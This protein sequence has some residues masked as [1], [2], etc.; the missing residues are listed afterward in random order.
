MMYNIFIDGK[1]GTTGLQ[2]YDRLAARTD[3]NLLTLPEEKRKDINA[4]KECLNNADIS[5]LCLP[6][7]AA[8]EAVSLVENPSARIIDASTAHRTAEGWIYGFPEISAKRR[9]EIASAKRVANPGCHATGF[10]S[11]AAPLVKGGI[12]GADYPFVAHSLT[13]YSGG[14]KKTI[15]EYQNKER[16]SAL[17]SPREYATK[18]MHKHLP[19]MV[20]ECG[21]KFA[22][23][24]N[25][26]ICDF[27]CGMCVAVPLTVRLLNKKVTVNDVYEYFAEYYATQNFIKIV[28][29]EDVPAYLPSDELAGTN[30]LKIYVNGSGEHIFIA[31]V[32]DNLGKGASGAAVQNMNIMLGIDERTSLV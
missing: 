4:R 6:D 2:I 19:E 5:F 32:F 8:R 27:Y 3:I 17:S 29:N 7:A 16:D 25:P 26:I 12:A 31:S 13:G 20:R 11:I 28:K 18:M 23:A 30:M 14:G 21:L 9:S 22:P 15:A 10:I 24:F 1:E